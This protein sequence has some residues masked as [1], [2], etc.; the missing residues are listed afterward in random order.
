MS[1]EKKP[2][3]K[4]FSSSKPS[5]FRWIWYLSIRVGNSFISLIYPPPTNSHHQDLSI[6]S[7]ESQPKPSFVTV[8]GWGV[9]L[10]YISLF[11]IFTPPEAMIS[12]SA[13]GFSTTQLAEEVERFL[14]KIRGLRVSEANK[15]SGKQI[16]VPGSSQWQIFGVFYSWPI[17][18]KGLG[19]FFLRC[20]FATFSGVKTWLPFGWSKCHLEEAM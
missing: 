2:S 3:Q 4:A 13:R 1:T 16:H 5:I 9:D 18:W 20:L 19:V 8:T 14:G 12:L 7:R 11:R 17:F 10:I 6:F 15:N